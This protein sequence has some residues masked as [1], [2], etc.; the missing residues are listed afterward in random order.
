MADDPE[1]ALGF[2]HVERCRRFVHDDELCI[3]QKRFQNLDHLLLGNAQR[4]H[5]SVEIKREIALFHKLPCTA[6]HGFFTQEKL[7][8][9]QLLPEE[10]VLDDA[11]C[12]D[13]AQLLINDGNA[14]RRGVVLRSDI[15]LFPVHPNLAA[16]CC[17]NAGQNLDQRRFARTV[18]THQRVDLTV[19]DRE[20]HVIQHQHARKLLPDVL[21]LKKLSVFLTHTA[22]PSA[23][24]AF[25]ESLLRW[26]MIRI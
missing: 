25:L 23:L 22:P 24:A 20:I 26:L 6:V 19:T 5:R 2:L 17:I 15:D 4:F 3:V 14:V 13:E 11:Q 18:F 8:L 12:R 7:A 10:H 21:H 16:V 1:Q 9:C